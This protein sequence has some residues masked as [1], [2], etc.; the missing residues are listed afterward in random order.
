V[1]GA[2]QLLR[3]RHAG[4]PEPI[5][6]TACRRARRASGVDPALLEGAVDDVALDVLDGDRIVVDVEDAGLLARRRA[7]AAGEL[8]E[9]VGRVQALDRLAASG[10]GTRDRSS[11]E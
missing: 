2:R 10:R 4:G 7:D 8:G 1:A 9:V 6:A 5:T 3:A 11:R